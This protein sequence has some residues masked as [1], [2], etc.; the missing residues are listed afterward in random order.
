MNEYLC[1]LMQFVYSSVIV[2]LFFISAWYYPRIKSLW[3]KK[4]FIYIVM[5]IFFLILMSSL[6]VFSEIG[7][8]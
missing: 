7:F 3:V 5:G 2:S 4:W 1:I 6:M 8:T